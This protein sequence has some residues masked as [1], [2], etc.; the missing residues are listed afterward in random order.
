MRSCHRRLGL[1]RLVHLKAVG[2][3]PMSLARIES[4]MN[5]RARILLLALALVLPASCKLQ[6]PTSIDGLGPD[7]V[8]DT[9]VIV[10][11]NITVP[12][13]DS[14]AFVAP[15]E[16]VEGT[17]VSGPVEW[18]VSGGAGGR[19]GPW[20]RQWPLGAMLPSGR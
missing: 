15:N 11:Q 7:P 2:F 1:F 10:P 20:P 17:V 18:T 12:L 13:G 14:I 6:E 19:A 9:L 8:A 4:P 16:T 5:A 3:P